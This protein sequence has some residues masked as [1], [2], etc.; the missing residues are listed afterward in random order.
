M[1]IQTIQNPTQQQVLVVSQRV[2][3]FNFILFL[4]RKEILIL[5]STGTSIRGRGGVQRRGAN[6]SGGYNPNI[7][8][9]GNDIPQDNNAPLKTFFRGNSMRGRGGFHPSSRPNPMSVAPNHQPGMIQ[10]NMAVKR[11]PPMPQPGP[12]RGNF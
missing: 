5:F 12:K 9:T 6:S 7:N 1:Q 4:I 2:V 3:R 10:P 8:V 11:G